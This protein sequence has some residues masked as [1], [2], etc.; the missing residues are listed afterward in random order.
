M[1]PEILMD[2][3]SAEIVAALSAMKQAK[4]TEERLKQSEI[5]KNL[6]E[7]LGVFLNL[8]EP[9]PLL[10]DDDDDQPIPF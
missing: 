9:L 2:G 8:I 5:V 7:S 10:D 3:I 6:C 1:D 4:S